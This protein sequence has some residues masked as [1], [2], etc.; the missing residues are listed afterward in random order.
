M[1]LLAG[2]LFGVVGMAWGQRLPGN[3]RPE[4]Y[5]V[6][7]SPDLKTATFRGTETIDAV[8]AEPSTSITVNAAELGIQ[9]VS[10]AGQT[11]VVSFD[12][13]KE[14][15]TFRFA[16]ALPAG[17]VTLQVAFT[18]ALNDKLRGFY[19]SKSKVRSY[20]VTQFEATDARRAFPCFDEPALKATFDVSLTVDAGDT[21]I[22]NTKIVEDRAAGFG[23]HTLRFATTPKMSTYLVAWLV[24]DFACTQGKSE[25][26]PIRVCTTPDKVELTEFAL[27]G[28]EHFLKYYDRYFGIKYPLGK[29]DLVGIPDFE[30]GAME[31]FGAITYRETALLVDEKRSSVNERKRVAVTV[32]HEM[33]HQWFGDL[34]TMGWWDNLWL[35]EGF[36]TWMESKAANEW[37]PGWEFK[38][39][40]ATSLDETLNYDAGRTTRTIRARAETPSEISELFDGIAYGK[41]GAVIGMVENWV[42]EKVFQAGVHAYLAAHLYGNATAE[43]FWEAQTAVSRQPVDRVMRSFVD[44]AGVPVLKFGARQAVGVPV[45]QGRFYLAGEGSDAR[46]AAAVSAGWVVPVCLKGGSGQACSLVEKDTA[47]VTVPAGGAFFFAN[48]GDKGYYR[49]E[50]TPEQARAITAGVETGLSAPERIGFVG[51]RWALVRAGDI[52]VGEFLDLALAVKGDA[53]PQVVDA[54]LNAVGQVR[55]KIA[56]AEERKRL[57]AVVRAEFGPVYAGL[58]PANGKEN[59]DRGQIRTELFEALGEAEDPAVLAHAREVTEELFSGKKPTEPDIVDA[60]VALAAAHGDRAFYEKVLYVSQKATDPGLAGETLGMLTRFHEPILV[61]R[62]LEYAVSGEVRNQDAWELVARE[63]SQGETRELAWAWVRQHWDTVQAVLTT[64]TGADVVGA[65]GSFC[66]VEGRVQ[67]GEFFKRHP[68]AAADRTLKKA[69][70]SIDACV[71]LRETQEPKLAEWLAARRG[72]KDRADSLR[73]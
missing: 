37:Q 42:G 27:K 61:I 5:A 35:N 67:V 60:S 26:V 66:T 9:S 11:G 7:I 51:E 15:A 68:V 73:E 21:A 41:A 38:E 24:G 49:V 48:A 72:A 14:Q 17:R 12:V 30:A 53:N 2:I 16:Q 32:A 55:S 63:L 50:Y 23:K 71:R 31:N 28:A 43:D 1:R 64:G 45:E 54:A 25:G 19:L 57:N 20:A 33:A 56:T 29:L 62:T 47:A 8:L 18:G 22:S 44:G 40:D 65:T 13:E 46:D 70:D 52:G 36:A 6:A 58:G 59:F 34:V 39:D 10:A 4:H 3:V 69:L